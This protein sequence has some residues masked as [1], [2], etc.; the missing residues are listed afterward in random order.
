MYDCKY[1]NHKERPEDSP[2]EENRL[3]MLLREV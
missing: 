3:D 2:E 1:Y